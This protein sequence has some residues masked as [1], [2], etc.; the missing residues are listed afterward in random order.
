M[1]I[2]KLT[3][4]LSV[5]PQI[6]L[7]ELDGIK[8]AG[9]RS[10]ISDRPDGEAGDQPTFAEIEAA[11]RK[12]GLEAAHVPV[13]SGWIDAADVRAF[14]EALERLPKPTLGF[15]RTG[16]RTTSLWAMSQGESKPIE[17]ILATAKAAGYDVSG[18]T[19]RIING[20]DLQADDPL[21]RRQVVI[22]GGGAQDARCFRDARLVL[23]LLELRLHLLVLG[24]FGRLCALAGSAPAG[25]GVG[26]WDCIE[27]LVAGCGTWRLLHLQGLKVGAKGH[28]GGAALVAVQQLL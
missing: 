7:D 2:N 3:N 9:F 1:N 8:A 19:A 6:G 4:D 11:A 10:I 24:K 12:A 26:L 5:S 25:A 21:T 23:F 22:V 18:S 16:M 15:C 14:A 28:A 20:G 27:G 13:V 17:E